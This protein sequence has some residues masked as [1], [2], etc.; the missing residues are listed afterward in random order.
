MNNLCGEARILDP[1]LAD[2]IENVCEACEIRKINARSKI[3]CKVS[4]THVN[5]AFNEEA[6]INFFYATLKGNHYTI[7][8]MADTGTGLSDLKIT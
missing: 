8:T 7:M 6:W 2:T 3:T 5:R 1:K 4:I